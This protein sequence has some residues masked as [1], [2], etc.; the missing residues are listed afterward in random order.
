MQCRSRIAHVLALTGIHLSSVRLADDFVVEVEVRVGLVIGG[1]SDPLG[2]RVVDDGDAEGVDEE[3][4]VDVDA[5][6]SR[7]FVEGFKV[8]RVV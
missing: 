4:L 1:H 5:S 7:G 6:P 8:F 3:T 2:I